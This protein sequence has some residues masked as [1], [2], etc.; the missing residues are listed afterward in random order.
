LASL[1]R[2]VQKLIIFWLFFEVLAVMWPQKPT[3]RMWQQTAPWTWRP[4]HQVA[5]SVI[6]K[7]S[8]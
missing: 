8:D 7:A 6:K 1:W 5:G 2:G 4:L 3:G